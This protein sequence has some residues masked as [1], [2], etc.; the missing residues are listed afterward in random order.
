[1]FIRTHFQS[2][3]KICG[4]D[5]PVVGLALNLSAG[6]T[7]RRVV[8]GSYET[9]RP[10]FGMVN[11]LPPAA[12]SEIHVDGRSRVMLVGM[13]WSSVISVL[14]ETQ[15]VDASKVELPSLFHVEDPHLTHLIVTAGTRGPKAA[16]AALP[17][18]A[19]RLLTKHSNKASSAKSFHA[20][21][22]PPTKLRSVLERIEQ[23][24]DQPLLLHEL[25]ASTHLSMFHF[26]R[27]FAKNVGMP[28]RA[29]ILRRRVYRAL[30]LLGTGLFSSHAAAVATG[31]VDTSHLARQFRIQFGIPLGEYRKVVL[32]PPA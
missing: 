16:A 6:H 18:L 7:V 32:V 3:S 8:C 22:L 4:G 11:I 12:T 26:A 20:G 24:L 27:E 2:G 21:G 5:D 28:P 17:F 13:N 29:Y 23:D 10:R 1:M 14:S 19:E 31:F 15:D 25:A 30:E 9:V